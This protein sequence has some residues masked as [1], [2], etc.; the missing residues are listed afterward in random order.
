[1]GVEIRILGSTT[2]QKENGEY[3]PSLLTGSKRLALLTY[4]ILGDPNGFKRRDK[5]I[6]LFWPKLNQQKA[7]NA[8]SNLLYHIRSS[9]GKEIIQNR[10]SEEISVNENHIWCDVLAFEDLMHDE[11]YQLALDLYRDDLLVGFHVTDVSN[12]FYN[13]LD[14]KRERLRMLAH[15]AS[16]KLAEKAEE[17]GDI[18]AAQIWAKKAVDYTRLSEEAH[19]RLIE[20][21]NRTGQP[22][23]ALKVYQEFSNKLEHKWQVTPSNALKTTIERIRN[24]ISSSNTNHDSAIKESSPSIAVLPF[25]TLRSSDTSSTFTNGIHDDL[26]TRLSSI[27]GIEVTSRTSVMRYKKAAIPLKQ[28]S[29]EL[30]VEWILEGTVQQVNNQVKVRVRLINTTT[31][32]Q[33]WSKDFENK[34]NANNL[35]RIQ[36]TIT[37]KIAEALKTKLSAKEK[38]RVEV[39]HTDQL[40]AY[41]LYTQ[42]WSWVEQ[43]TQKGLK[44]GLSCFK[45]ASAVDPEFSLSLVGQAHA[46]LGLFGYGY[47]ETEKILSEAEELIHQ[48]L[49]QDANLAE[50]HSALGLLHTS[51]QEGREAIQALK[52]A[53]RL[54]PGYA[55]AHNKLSWI[56]QLMGNKDRALQ[57]AKKAVDLDPFSPEAVINLA[58]SYLINGHFSDALK[59]AWQAYDLQSDWPTASFY[60]ALIHYQR[61]KYEESQKYLGE[62]TVPWTNNGPKLLQTLI[63]IKSSKNQSAEYHLKYFIQEKDFFSQG[64]IHAALNDIDKAF[65]A[66]ENIPFWRPWPTQ[67]MHHLFPR[68]LNAIKKDSRYISLLQNIDR[69][70]GMQ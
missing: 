6:A 11:K 7:R 19:I 51:R 25:E 47:E 63:N 35:F 58:Y 46:L 20:L 34:L 4:L 68:E 39:Q 60:I 41:R 21:L 1:M 38:K 54:R 37:K 65:E 17:S 24:Q 15:D 69:D 18:K 36:S 48:A 12:D 28:I 26:L 23:D 31:D 43:R 33:Y 5:I 22:T 44:R 56:Y 8:L 55:N 62:L 59:Y 27:S 50:A 2:I 53:V 13:W 52:K 64:V 32:R 10:G 9:L 30:G 57:S 67:V 40:E 14:S 70:W 16:W 45:E 42:G 49:D 66:F 3:D 61:E 29:A